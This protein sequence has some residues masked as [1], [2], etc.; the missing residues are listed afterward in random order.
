MYSSHPFLSAEVGGV[1]VTTWRSDFIKKEI[2]KTF[3]FIFLVKTFWI[4]QLLPNHN[5]FIN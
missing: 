1:S 3:F 5:G 2:S 4:F